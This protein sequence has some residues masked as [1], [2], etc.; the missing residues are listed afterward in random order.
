MLDTM[1]STIYGLLFLILLTSLHAWCYY[2]LILKIRKMGAQV[3]LL[4]GG[5]VRIQT[6]L[7]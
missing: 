1:E 5:Q 4:V 3:L 6:H 7:V 2:Y